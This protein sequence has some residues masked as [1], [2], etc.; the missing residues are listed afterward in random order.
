MIEGYVQTGKTFYIRKGRNVTYI[1][2]SLTL[3][4][5]K[6]NIHNPFVITIYSVLVRY[7]TI[8][9]PCPRAPVAI[10]FCTGDLN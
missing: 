7:G 2:R 6:F 3:G 5:Q 8:Y 9:T 1:N 10:R 4:K